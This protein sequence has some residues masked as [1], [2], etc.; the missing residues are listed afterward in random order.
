MAATHWHRLNETKYKFVRHWASW[1]KYLKKNIIATT[2]NVNNRP[3]DD[4]KD[5]YLRVKEQII[6]LNFVP[7][8][9]IGREVS[10]RTRS[11]GLPGNE[12]T[13][14]SWE[15]GHSQGMIR[16]DE[17]LTLETSAFESLHGGQF[18]LST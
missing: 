8:V 15:R 13:R 18:T 1:A 9:F 3:V 12:V 10:L 17:G 4:R 2:E 16:S 6:E 5:K 7:M 14:P 11:H